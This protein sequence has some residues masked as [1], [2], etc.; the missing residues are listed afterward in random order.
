MLSHPPD[1]EMKRG[2][3]QGTPDFISKRQP[4]KDSAAEQN[5]QAEIQTRRVARLYAAARVLAEFTGAAVR[6]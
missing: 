3:C 5:T 1:P 2:A 6:R 4:N